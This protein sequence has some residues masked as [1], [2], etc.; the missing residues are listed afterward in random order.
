MAISINLDRPVAAPTSSVSESI[1]VSTA[2]ATGSDIDFKVFLDDLTIP[3]ITTDTTFPTWSTGGVIIQGAAGQFDD[4]RIGDVVSSAVDFNG[5]NERIVAAVDLVLF[6]VTLTAAPAADATSG[7]E[8][9][10]FTAGSTGDLDSTLYHVKLTHVVNGTT[11]TVTPKFSCH[12]GNGVFEGNPVGDANSD[13][14]VF[15]DGNV[16]TLPSITINLDSYL[17]NA[18]VP[19]A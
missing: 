12:D 4:V 19:R 3:T 13:D 2:V 14:V 1:E 15:A 16:K 11:L 17:T 18:R 9:L 5:A 8:H 7:A 10:T 6:Q